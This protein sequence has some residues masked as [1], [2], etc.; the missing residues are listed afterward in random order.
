MARDRGEAERLAGRGRQAPQQALDIRLVTGP[1][2]TEHVGVE[3]HERLHEP[4][5]SR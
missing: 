5:A 2:A 4:T 1:L 3:S